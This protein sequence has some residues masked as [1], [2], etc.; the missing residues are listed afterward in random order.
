MF[1][2]VFASLPF[3]VSASGMEAYSFN[4]HQPFAFTMNVG[5]GQSIRITVRNGRYVAHLPGGG[6]QLLLKMDVSER[7]K[8]E[9]PPLLEGRGRI[10]VADITFDGNTDILIH[11]NIGYGGV[12]VF[13]ST[14]P[15][16][17]A[18]G[19]FRKGPQISNPEI[20]PGRKLLRTGERSG[21]VWHVK[22]YR[23]EGADLWKW[24][25]HYAPGPLRIIRYLNRNGK[26]VKSIVAAL[27]PEIEDVPDQPEPAVMIVSARR[28]HFHRR[29][30]PRS[31]TRSFLVRGDEVTVLDAREELYSFSWFK[32]RHRGKRGTV[33]GWLKADTLLLPGFK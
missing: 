20:L 16:D 23:G 11:D 19:R 32:V 7:S 13:Y 14:F 21:P 17:P 5:N 1:L 22:E 3:A 25:Y 6:R 33:S 8:D 31:R 26:V 2:S 10:L 15:W 27:G 24:R 18:A 9:T 30:D 29:P 28:S 4:P 12:N